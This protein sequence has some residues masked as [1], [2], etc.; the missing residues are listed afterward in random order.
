[1]KNVIESI[2]NKHLSQQLKNVEPLTRKSMFDLP[3]DKCNSLYF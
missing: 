2:D 1:M 3:W